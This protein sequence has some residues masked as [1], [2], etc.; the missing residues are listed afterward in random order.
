MA[1]KST[2]PWPACSL[3]V[4][5]FPPRGFSTVRTAFRRPS[6]TTRASDSSRLFAISSFILDGYRPWAEAERS[7]RVRTQN[8]TPTPSPLRP[9]ARRIWASLPPAS[10]PAV[11]DASAALRFRSV[12]CR[13][14]GLP[15][16]APSRAFPPPP[17]RA[18]PLSRWCGFPP[19]GL[20]RG[21]ASHRIFLL[22]Y[23]HLMFCAHAGRTGL[24]IWIP[25]LTLGQEWRGSAYRQ[26]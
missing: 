18:A 6:G 19:S 12:R 25:I 8:F 9:S 21:L 11:S 10:S 22:C 1:A 13:T 23:S 17:P 24:Q 16:D 4:L 15:S 7:P 20:P 2:A 26:L 14:F 3:A 5:A